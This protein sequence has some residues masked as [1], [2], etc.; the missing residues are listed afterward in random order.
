MSQESNVNNILFK[1]LTRFSHLLYPSNS[2]NS[3]AYQNSIL[4]SL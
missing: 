3:L 4:F 2:C 1:T